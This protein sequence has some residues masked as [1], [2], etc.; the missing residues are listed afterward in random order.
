MAKH[1]R[2]EEPESASAHG[3]NT[4]DAAQI[5]ALGLNFERIQVHAQRVKKAASG[6]IVTTL[7]CLGACTT[8]NGGVI[9]W[10]RAVRFTEGDWGGRVRAFADSAQKYWNA[11]YL[12]TCIPAAGAASR[13]LASVRKFVTDFECLLS[14]AHALDDP[15]RSDLEPSSSLP[16][17]SVG[18]R[19]ALRHEMQQLALSPNL[20]QLSEAIQA[21]Y[22]A[23][24]A[25]AN[26]AFLA[27][28]RHVT[29]DEAL[30]SDL[31]GRKN[32]GLLAEASAFAAQDSFAPMDAF[33]LTFDESVI[34]NHWEPF[35]GK[36][37][38]VRHRNVLGS[39]PSLAPLDAWRS[40]HLATRPLRIVA[41]TSAATETFS[42]L[43]TAA[44]PGGPLTDKETDVLRIYCDCRS[45]LDVYE[46]A[47]KAFV[48][49][50]AEGDDFLFLKIVEQMS[51][52]PC[53]GNVLVCPAGKKAEFEKRISLL[54]LRLLPEC[55]NL[56]ELVRT[57]FAPHWLTR[58]SS[59]AAPAVTGAADAR[60][61]TDPSVRGAWCVMEQGHNL[62]TIRFDENGQP[63]RLADGR[64]SMV[65]A[66]HGE[67]V[68]IFADILKRF[69]EAECLHIRNIDNVIGTG[70]ERRREIQTPSRVFRVVRDCLEALRFYFDALAS[71][72]TVGHDW[73][74]LDARA[75]GAL[76]TLARLAE[77]WQQ[78]DELQLDA[79]AMCRVT[80]DILGSLF[81]W[82]GVEAAEPV[83]LRARRLSEW[84]ARPLSV[85]G[86][87]RKE[88]GDVGGGPVF[89]SLADG[90]TIKLCMEM[91]HASE[92]DCELY[93]GAR[94]RATHFNPVLV[95]FELQTHK[96]VSGVAPG[97]HASAQATGRAVDFAS[98]FDDRFW[99]LARKD[100]E[101]RRVCYH[102][103]VLYELIG[104]SARTN[105]L[106]VEVPRTL[107]NPHKTFMDG[108]GQ[109]RRSYGFG[110]TLK[111]QDERT[112][113]G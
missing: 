3:D 109:D 28:G 99:L 55:R 21:H 87:V 34:R 40:P 46:T 4:L 43:A 111:A 20:R 16:G 57:P 104:N 80:T 37:T 77:T 52:L 22:P 102:E 49:T 74:W 59:K 65:S 86:V 71:G 35:G 54:G 112:E 97:D 53:N 73:A 17:L 58:W 91:P 67:L 56:F 42:S 27:L 30:P 63:T 45:L 41:S 108:L 60:L 79:A 83:V 8:N 24:T 84:L 72:S 10:K 47:P 23:V 95:F 85:F 7:P 113:P 61:E 19:Q 39:S 29:S 78:P 94:G 96:P 68:H 110:E 106:F 18:A 100:F 101:G 11:R 92:A 93:F 103:T 13:Y 38:S 44:R 48:P 82:P 33:S 32:K 26:H 69:P 98:L 1:T 50:T 25:L 62:S 75:R 2:P 70:S 81:H 66:G 6:Q 12:V 9:S 51:L 15:A 105:L 5:A 36:A 88:E 76:T 64:Y 89:T 31:I 14:A 90:G 107:F